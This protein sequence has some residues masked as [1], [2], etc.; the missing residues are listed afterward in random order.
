MQVFLC[1]V[2]SCCQKSVSINAED[3]SGKEASKTKQNHVA[4]VSSRRL[5]EKQSL[6][7]EG[8]CGTGRRS[9]GYRSDPTGSGPV[10]AA[11]QTSVSP[12]V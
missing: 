4:M 2:H 3:V 11:G 12:S 1:D 5:R 9:W 6:P 10:T 8:G 7:G